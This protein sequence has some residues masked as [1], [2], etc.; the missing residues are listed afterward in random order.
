MHQRKHYP[1]LD[2]LRGIGFL[3]VFA[4]HF[5]QAYKSFYIAG[6]VGVG[7]FFVLSGLFLMQYFFHSF[8]TMKSW[9]HWAIYFQ[10]RILRLYP[11]YIVV[12]FAEY[13]L[14]RYSLSTMVSHF[15]LIDGRQHYWTLP[16]EFQF[17]AVMPF[18]A[19]ICITV[20]KNNYVRCLAF[21]TTVLTFTGIWYE[22]ITTPFKAPLA[23]Q[24]NLLFYLPAFM[25]GLI[26]AY[27][28]KAYEERKF[29]ISK[30]SA[31]VLSLVSIGS[32]LLLFPIS[33][34]A[35][36]KAGAGKALFWLFTGYSTLWSVLVFSLITH[37]SLLNRFFEHRFIRHLG[38]ISYSAY[39]MHILVIAGFQAL[40][41]T[42]RYIGFAFSFIATLALSSVTYRFVEKPA[43]QFG[44]MKS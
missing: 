27:I 1:A 35:F 17:Y 42:D 6:K 24:I 44:I 39:L 40:F 25:V 36:W 3:I 11:M 21:I 5:G 41:P 28:I 31:Y 29:S 13:L 37:T 43:L 2:G 9:R 10:R 7:L 8:V 18:V 15:L 33:F 26:L 19:Y 14:G 22:P 32:L 38:A 4:A 16:V 34:N 30:P 23:S 12:L 20:F